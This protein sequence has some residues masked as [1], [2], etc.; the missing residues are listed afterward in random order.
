MKRT[1]KKKAKKDLLDKKV[2][3]GLCAEDKAALRRLKLDENTSYAELIRIALR[4]TY[5]RYFKHD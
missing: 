1:I 4:S 3:T 2:G 5:P